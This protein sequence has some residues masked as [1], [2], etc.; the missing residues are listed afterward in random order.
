MHAYACAHAHQWLC[1]CARFVPRSV[2]SHR[3]DPSFPLHTT[4]S[5]VCSLA[6]DRG[7]STLCLVL[8]LLRQDMSLNMATQGEREAGAGSAHS[9]SAHGAWTVPRLFGPGG[10]SNYAAWRAPTKAA[11]MRAGVAERDYSDAKRATGWAELA[12]KVDAW[13]RDDEE[14][15][16][17][18]A[19]G[20]S[21]KREQKGAGEEAAARRGAQEAVLRTR[22]AFGLLYAAL[23]ENHRSLV[24]GIAQDVGLEGEPAE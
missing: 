21:L 9:G 6:A 15:S 1:C 17:N 16:I 4:V 12:A 8:S 20:V 18:Y 10:A 24:A 14:A 3:H 7:T 23:D 19:L 11:L 22:R 5:S 2:P 13:T